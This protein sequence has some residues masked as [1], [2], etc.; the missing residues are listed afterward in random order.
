MEGKL[1]P[2]KSG[3]ENRPAVGLMTQ[4]TYELFQETTD[5]FPPE[6]IVGT[7]FVSVATGLEAVEHDGPQPQWRSVVSINSR[8]WSPYARD[9]SACVSSFTLCL[10]TPSFLVISR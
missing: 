3:T 5:E 8:D 4:W 10:T 2:H 7:R 9:V 1:D 6:I